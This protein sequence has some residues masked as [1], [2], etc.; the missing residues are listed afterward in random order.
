M[1]KSQIKKILINLSLA[2]AS[3]DNCLATDRIEAE[4][5]ETSWRINFTNELNQIKELATM[6]GISLDI[7]LQYNDDSKSPLN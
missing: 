6:L 3:N 4:E 5:D 2:L 1:N 7:D